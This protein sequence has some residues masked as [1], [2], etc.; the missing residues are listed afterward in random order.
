MRHDS[1]EFAGSRVRLDYRVE[2]HYDIAGDADFVFS[3]HAAQTQQQRVLREAVIVEPAVAWHVETEPHS[4]NRLLRLRAG[5]SGLDVDYAASVEVV[6]HL[7]A[8]DRVLAGPIADLP[9]AILPFL[10]PSRYCQS[11]HVQ[12]FAWRQFGNM[13]PGYA[14]V[15]A[16][17][18]HVRS[19]VEFRVGTSTPATSAVDT[20]ERGCGVC[21]D[22][23]H[24]TIALLRAL[25]YPA[26]FVTGVDYGAPRDLGPPDFHS[27]VEAWIGGR[28]WLFDPTGITPLTGL[29]RI[30]TGRDAADVAFATMFGNVRGGMPK[31]AFDAVEDPAAGLALPQRTTLAVSTAAL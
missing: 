19:H 28:W 31:L 5:S 4:G 6:H 29:I 30:G 2:L 24:A 13:E 27:Y 8:P 26:R 11:D 3:I 21:R 12:A 25:N 18:N 20:L 9:V 22:F 17:C 10:R 1:A 7:A 14:Q 16:V 15:E 23:V